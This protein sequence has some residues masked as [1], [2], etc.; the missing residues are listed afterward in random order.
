MLDRKVEATPLSVS[1][2]ETMNESNE[3]VLKLCCD[4]ESKWAQRA[5]VKHIQ[6]GGN[7]TKYFHIT[8]NGK[9]R[10]KNI[11]LKMKVL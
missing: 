4:A 11:F 6:E 1:Q 7:N 2:R 3:K 9:H 10:R 8:A 5:K